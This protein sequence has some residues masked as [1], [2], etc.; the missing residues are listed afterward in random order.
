MSA[1]TPFK[2]LVPFGDC[3]LDALFFFGREREIE[4]IA[5]NL[6]ASKL[7][8]LY[9][10]T[11]VGK[12]SVLRAGVVRSLRAVSFRR[13]LVVYSN[14][15]DDPVG[16]VAQA[17]A[18]AAGVVARSSLAETL[19]DAGAA[20]DGELYL[21]L[22]QFEEYFVYHGAAL[23]AGSFLADLAAALTQSGVRVNILLCLREDSLARVDVL[24]TR[25]PALFSN[26]L[27]LDHLTRAAARSA[28]VGPV[29]R[30]NELFAETPVSVEPALVEA[31]LDQVESG[32]VEGRARAG[33]SVDRIEAPYLQLVLE[34]LWEVERRQGS[35]VLR[36]ET[37]DELGGAVRIVTEHLERAMRELSPEEQSLAAALFHQMVTPSGTKI[38]HTIPDLARYAS[39]DDDAVHGVC[40]RLVA[41]RILRPVAGPPGGD[42]RVEIFHDVLAPAVLIWSTRFDAQRSEARARRAAEARRRRATIVA[43]ASLLALIVV[44][45]IA[46]FALTQRSQAR[47]SARSARANALT[48]KALLL[49]SSDPGQAVVLALQASRLKS[50]AATE[51]VLR[52]SL[53]ASRLRRTLHVGGSVLALQWLAPGRLAVGGDNGRV[54]LWDIGRDTVT[55]M[56]AGAPVRAMA[57]DASTGRLVVLA[58]GKATAWNPATGEPGFSVAAEDMAVSGDGSLIAT[59]TA[60][61][62][63][64][65]RASGGRL[66]RRL[67]APGALHATFSPDGQTLAVVRVLPGGRVTSFTYDVRTSELLAELPQRGIRAVA[68]AP[69]SSLLA[70]GSANGAVVLWRPRTGAYVRRLDDGGG[71]IADLTFNKDG[72]MLATASRDG[73]VRVWRIEDGTRF[74][75]FL[76][77]GAAVNR[78]AFSPDDRYLASTSDDRT[79][80]IWTVSDIGAGKL[81]AVLAGS[82]GAVG[83]VA[84][85]PGGHSLVTASGDGAVRI[86]EPR[87]EQ[88][89]TAVAEDP[90][91]SEAVRVLPGGAGLST[92]A[93]AV[94]RTRAVSGLRSFRLRG[95]VYALS[96]ARAAAAAAGREIRVQSIPSG[97]VV[98]V[99]RAPAPVS[100]L[101]FRGDGRQLVALAGRTVLVWDVQSGRL[102]HHFDG[103]EGIVRVALAPDGQRVATGE[104]SGTVRIWSAAGAKLRTLFF[105]HEPVTDIRFAADGERAVTASEGSS[106]NA[107]LWDVASGRRVASLIG[108]FGTVTAASFSQDGRWI[109]TAGPVSAAVWSAA[110]GQLLFYLR[111][112]S[113]LLTDAEWSPTG[114]TVASTERDGTVREYRCVVCRPLSD[115]QELAERRLVAMR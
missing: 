73:G 41:E 114:F 23:A 55:R 59:V 115:L 1:A 11:G 61:G 16:R 72:S 106:D 48:A 88:Q 9:G 107:A 14:W 3:D 63:A 31:V 85:A 35:L 60:D 113:S 5:A 65:R 28:I 81:A 92:V 19:A 13:E 8:V 77:H 75:L 56:D 20:L 104:R 6:L 22:D 91:P 30:W 24:K 95:S 2:G 110:S 89:L 103:G 64:L 51:S 90:A 62:V 68:F 79:A 74:F 21:I 87:I 12:T 52:S 83:A 29:A 102:L 17:V 39:M 34:R 46:I 10:P 69:D 109:L 70:T 40:D 112:P 43:A 49:Q 80:R 67:A 93:G 53:M 86:W 18:E 98:G 84:Y 94:V 15:T 45:A 108:Q 66:V 71:A 37:L 97:A 25:V 50:D 76:G 32:N 44:G 36:L 42:D 47:T 33:P 54:S 111:G 38:A 7:T 78:V 100:T 27:R 26:Y 4:L 57:W 99:I 82:R 101:G 105:H 96:A 58:G